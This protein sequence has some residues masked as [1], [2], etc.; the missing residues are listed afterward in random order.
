MNLL[1]TM[2]KPFVIMT[3][4]TINDPMGGYMTR[5]V[6]GATF[7]AFVRK[8]T[9]PEIVVAEKTDV[10]ETLT[11]VVPKGTPLAYHSVVKRLSDEETY[12]LISTLVDYEAP[13]ASS[14]QIARADCE[15]WELT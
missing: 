7:D 1:A 5:W 4:V 14:V 12:R 3:A 13:M 11:I 10:K 9:A 2:M 15:R 8:E 6:E